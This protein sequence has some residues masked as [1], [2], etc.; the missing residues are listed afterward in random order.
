MTRPRS[1]I[2]QNKLKISIKTQQTYI[3]I[4]QTHNK[5]NSFRSHADVVHI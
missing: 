4:Q 1:N 5:A 2:A 3:C